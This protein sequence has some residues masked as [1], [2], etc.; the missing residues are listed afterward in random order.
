MP[1]SSVFYVSAVYICRHSR[2]L[3]PVP[4]NICQLYWP[5]SLWKVE[6]MKM[7]DI[8]NELCQTKDYFLV[9]AFIMA[10]RA[11]RT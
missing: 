2:S 9:C 6:S 7:S 3:N 4:M 1:A 5:Y 11:I 10:N 8:H